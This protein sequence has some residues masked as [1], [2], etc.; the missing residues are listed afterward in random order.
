M[1]LSVI[2]WI[3][4]LIVVLIALI[5]IMFIYYYN[6]FIILENR[7]E[8]SLA[9]IDVQLK[10]RAD[11]VPNL[12]KTVKGYVKHEKDIFNK[13]TKARTELMKSKDLGKRV[14]AGDILQG[15]LSRLIAIA[16]SNPQI[17]A[18]QNFLHL[19]QELS[20]IE[21]K[22]AF[23]RQYYNDSIMDYQNLSESFPG[24]FFFNLYRREKKEFLEIPVKERKLPEIE[25]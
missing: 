6:R 3:L 11:L 22:V 12:V 25:F 1:P 14:K 24:V 23:A 21:D 19:Q 7:I 18:N 4:I 17:Q 13:I 9:Q 10:K 8:N 5:V 15:F 20:A 16:E 2:L